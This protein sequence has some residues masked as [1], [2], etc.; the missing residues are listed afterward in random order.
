VTDWIGLAGRHYYFQQF[1]LQNEWKP[2]A[3]PL[4]VQFYI[5]GCVLGSKNA[6]FSKKRVKKLKTLHAE[7]LG[8]S[9]LAWAIFDCCSSW[10]HRNNINFIYIKN[11]KWFQGGN[12]YRERQKLFHYQIK[13][14]FDFAEE[15]FSQNFPEWISSAECFRELFSFHLVFLIT[16]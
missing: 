5:C 10:P 7:L 1:R 4:A 6:L 9:W 14:I 8:I 11:S 2:A 16:G 13:L 15:I 3:F 12:F